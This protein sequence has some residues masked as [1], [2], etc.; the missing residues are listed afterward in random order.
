[1]SAK[2]QGTSE[3]FGSDWKTVIIKKVFFVKNY[4]PNNE[5]MNPAAK[6]TYVFMVK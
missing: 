6:L 4:T 5:N 3:D 1:M 2:G